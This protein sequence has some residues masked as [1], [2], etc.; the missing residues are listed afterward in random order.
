MQVVSDNG[1]SRACCYVLVES[2]MPAG[3]CSATYR[4]LS[5]AATATNKAESARYRVLA[6]TSPHSSRVLRS[7]RGHVTRKTHGQ[8]QLRNA[9]CADTELL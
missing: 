3:E 6:C 5:A 8:Q 1:P 7:G 9:W 4:L 2:L